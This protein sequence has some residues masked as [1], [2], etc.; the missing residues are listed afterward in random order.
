MAAIGWLPSIVRVEITPSVT[1]LNVI[2]RPAPSTATHCVVELHATAFSVSVPSIV[3]GPSLTLPVVALKVTAC[4]SLST[5]VHRLLDGSHDT[6]LIAFEPSIDGVGPAITLPVVGL[7]VSSRPLP[8]T[9]T[10]SVLDRQAT[11][12]SAFPES[13]GFAP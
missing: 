10:H 3:V 8:S 12:D 9:V 1:G 2:R 7:N 13:I 6:A 4:P 11:A 5:A